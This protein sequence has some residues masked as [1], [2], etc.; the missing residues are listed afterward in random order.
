MSLQTKNLKTILRENKELRVYETKKS[1]PAE[2]PG[3]F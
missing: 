2:R 3:F 1:R